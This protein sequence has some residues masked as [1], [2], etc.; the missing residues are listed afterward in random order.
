MEKINDDYVIFEKNFDSFKNLAEKA[1]T[2]K[3]SLE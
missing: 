2:N 1:L 3:N